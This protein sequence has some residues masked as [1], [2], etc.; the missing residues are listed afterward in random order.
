MFF[1]LHLTQK[2]L[3]MYIHT[4]TYSFFFL[5]SEIN[6]R[7]KSKAAN[8]D[9]KIPENFY[10]VTIVF[11]HSVNGAR[12]YRLSGGVCDI[13]MGWVDAKKECRYYRLCRWYV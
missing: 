13:L 12:R 5:G 10:K 11:G 3:R 1:P 7:P 9:R 2:K 4:L 8:N 6:W